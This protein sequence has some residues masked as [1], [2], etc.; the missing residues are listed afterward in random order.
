LTNKVNKQR[1]WKSQTL[2]NY[3]MLNTRLW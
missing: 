2:T 3:M 1:K